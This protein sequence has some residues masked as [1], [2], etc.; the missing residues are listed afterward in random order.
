[1]LRAYLETHDPRILADA[2]DS[3]LA[4][5]SRERLKSLLDDPDTP[6]IIGRALRRAH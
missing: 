6:N 1:V 3:S 5:P 2:P 4:Y